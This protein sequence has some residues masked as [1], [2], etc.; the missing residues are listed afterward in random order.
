MMPRKKVKETWTFII[1]IENLSVKRFLNV[2][3]VKFYKFNNYR[4][5]LVRKR[6]QKLVRNNPHYPLKKEQ[7]DIVKRNVKDIK[8][9]VMGMTCAEVTI[10]GYLD[11]CYEIA[12]D[13]VRLA[14][15]VLKLYSYQNDDFR[16][17]PIS[18]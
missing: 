3:N 14:L 12:L 8:D 17:H 16:L 5:D 15:C 7:D 18:R 6:Y 13:S 10:T 4:L 11:E 2:G 1:P 9:E